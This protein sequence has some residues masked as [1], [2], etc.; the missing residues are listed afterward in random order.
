MGK[1]AE[2]HSNYRPHLDCA[3]GKLFMNLVAYVLLS[4]P[5]NGEL[6]INIICK[7]DHPMQA[8]RVVPQIRRDILQFATA[9]PDNHLPTDPHHVSEN[10]WE[11]ERLLVRRQSWVL[12][13]KL[14]A[15]REHQ[16]DNIR[17]NVRQLLAIK[18]CVWR[19]P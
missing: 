6:M 15:E 4:C 17:G 18:G 9:F 14:W 10:V 13:H 11:I 12:T 1:G 8:D 5:Q 2:Y 3:N 7:V 19:L 16:P